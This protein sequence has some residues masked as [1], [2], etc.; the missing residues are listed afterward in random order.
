LLFGLAAV[1]NAQNTDIVINSLRC[2][3]CTDCGGDTLLRDPGESCFES[4]DSL[5]TAADTGGCQD[6]PRFNLYE[7]W[8][9]GESS[10]APFVN[11]RFARWASDT[12]YWYFQVETSATTWGSAPDYASTH[13][14]VAFS[15]GAGDRFTLVITY[16]PNSAQ[17]G[18]T[19]DDLTTANMNFWRDSDGDV[20]G[21]A[22]DGPA[23]PASDTTNFPCSSPTCDGYDTLFSSPPS[24]AAFARLR[25]FGGQAMVEIAI[26]R[27]DFATFLGLGSFTP[28]DARFWQMQTSTLSGPSHFAWNDIFAD[29]ELDGSSW[30]MDNCGTAL[31]VPVELMKFDVD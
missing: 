16:I 29:T 4:G 31:S 7:N 14:E 12:D 20:G 19:W 25:D 5:K 11:I 10:K 9:A 18:T 24:T 1:A 30:A 8:N 15:C 6:Y 22:N 28:C 23:V 26:D 3:D 21:T 17:I 2:Q 13:V 27:S